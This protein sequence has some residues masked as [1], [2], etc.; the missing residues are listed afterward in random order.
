M[1]PNARSR[2]AELRADDLH[3]RL[4]RGLVCPGCARSFEPPRP[5]LFSYNSPLGACQPCKGF[6]RVIAVDWDKVIPD[7]TKTLAQGCIKAWSGKSSEWERSMLLK[8]AKKR[9]IPTDV[10]WAKLDLEQQ[11]LV[12]DGEGT[13]EG[14][15]YPGV[16]AWFKWLETRTYKMHIRVFLARYREYVPCAT[17]NG[18]RLNALA[19]TYLVGGLDLGAWHGL[20]VEQARANLD[21]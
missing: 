8:F 15:K 18:A 16:A 4:A 2:R 5:G 17:C 12:V 1:P 11:R 9:K 13:W 7:K 14:G 20:T 19:R 3:V 6:G 21:A 10:A